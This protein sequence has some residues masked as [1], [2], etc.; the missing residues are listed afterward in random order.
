MDAVT[1]AM[2][3]DMKKKTCV[4]VI[5]SITRRDGL[6]SMTSS[7]FDYYRKTFHFSTAFK[8]HKYNEHFTLHN[9]FGQLSEHSELKCSI[10]FGNW[11]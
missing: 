4:F 5:N 7:Q 8:N 3:D 6:Y 10:L 1:Q 11:F 9:G 2:E